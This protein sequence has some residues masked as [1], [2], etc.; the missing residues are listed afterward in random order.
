MSLHCLS[1]ARILGPSGWIAGHTLVIDGPLIEAVVPDDLAPAGSRTLLEGGSLVPGF[2]DVQ[3]N[4]GGGVLFND[5]PTVEA[6]AAIGKAHRRFGTTGFLPTLISDSLEAVATAIAAV[7]QAIAAGVPGVLGIHVEGPFLNADKR[8][9]HHASRFR[10]IDAQAI[11]LLS[12][13]KSGATMV[14]LAPE[15]A[16]P[17]AVA[18]LARR[19]IVVMAGHS[20]ASYDA[21]AEARTAGLAGAT[22]LFNAMTQLEGRNPGLVGAALDMGLYAGIIADGHHVHPASLR[23]AYRV[24]GPDRLA[25]VTDAMPTVGS[26]AEQF[27]L[28]ETE[29]A[30][31]NGALRAADGTLAGSNLDM[32]LAVRNSMAML[33]IPVEEACRMA[34]LT[35]ATLLKMN[36]VR[37]AVA[38][39]MAADLVHLDDRLEVAGSWIAGRSTE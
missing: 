27:T 19:G 2:I 28:G 38:P 37:G 6:I 7:D 35:P 18:E 22:H 30:L 13:L 20:M 36:T 8:G 15:L 33:D 32:V 31:A 4:G 16:P 3:V 24:L 26:L 10:T 9:I 11:E 23:I 12:S 25:L 17:G 29:I 21:I 1:G 14:T 39:G 5:R 34:S